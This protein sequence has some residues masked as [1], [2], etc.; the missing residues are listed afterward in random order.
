ACDRNQIAATHGPSRLARPGFRGTL[1]GIIDRA[2]DELA[3]IFIGS[4]QIHAA[5]PRSH[6]RVAVF[7]DSQLPNRADKG[8][9]AISVNFL[10]IW[11]PLC[12]GRTAP[13]ILGI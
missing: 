7:C 11:D 5:I 4:K 8:K 6:F 13:E 2:K 9:A 12:A 3:S 1:L 10:K